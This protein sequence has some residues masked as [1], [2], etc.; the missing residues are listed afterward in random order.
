M[1]G[2]EA[3][4]APAV[5]LLLLTAPVASAVLLRSACITRVVSVVAVDIAE[6][7]GTQQ[8]ARH[9]GADRVLT[10]QDSAARLGLCTHSA[11]MTSQR[12]TDDIERIILLLPRHHLPLHDHAPS[13]LSVSVSRNLGSLAFIVYDHAD[14]IRMLA[15]S[16]RTYQGPIPLRVARAGPDDDECARDEGLQTSFA[17]ARR[18]TRVRARREGNNGW[19]R[20]DES[21]RAAGSSRRGRI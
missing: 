16:H 19:R 3:E 9:S 5:L 13:R 8:R 4:T 15:Q 20:T 2:A 21:G 14:D 12:L 6:W 7:R 10:P 1:E 18:A 17:E 11:E